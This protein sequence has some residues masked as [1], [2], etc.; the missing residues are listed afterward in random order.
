MISTSMP[1]MGVC[2]VLAAVAQLAACDG[3]AVGEESSESIVV[4]PACPS[5]ELRLY[6]NV[7]YTGS[8]Y[9]LD[10]AGTWTVPSGF[11]IRS[12]K[13][14]NHTGWFTSRVT[15]PFSNGQDVPV[16]PSAISTALSVTVEGGVDAGPGGP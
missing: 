7:N 15:T 14:A 9:C 16:A 4:D 3:P 5:F 2:C 1:R 6:S 11:D 8:H 10:G 13:T 12:Y